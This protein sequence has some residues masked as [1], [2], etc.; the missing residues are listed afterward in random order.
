MAQLIL[1]ERDLVMA[2]HLGKKDIRGASFVL[3]VESKLWRFMQE[4][5][6]ELGDSASMGSSFATTQ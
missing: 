2:S 5:G 1:L 4:F 3:G 6:S